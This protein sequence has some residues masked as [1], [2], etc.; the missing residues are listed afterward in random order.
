MHFLSYKYNLSFDALSSDLDE[1]V[2]EEK[3]MLKNTSIEDDFAT[4]VDNSEEA[5]QAAFDKEHQFQTSV[6]S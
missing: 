3:D 6:R 5:L 4:F 2:T 1:F